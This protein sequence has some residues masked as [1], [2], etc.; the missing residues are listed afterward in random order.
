M[1]DNDERGVSDFAQAWQ[2]QTLDITEPIAA[3]INALSDAER[4]LNQVQAELRSIRNDVQSLHLENMSLRRE[5]TRLRADIIA[6][7]PAR[8]S[9]YSPSENFARTS[10]N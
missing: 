6:R 2:V 8:I 1:N 9:P 5:L 3:T 7:P 4:L 10:K